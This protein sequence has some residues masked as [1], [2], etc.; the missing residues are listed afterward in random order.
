MV[1]DRGG[2]FRSGIF[3]LWDSHCRGALMIHLQCEHCGRKLKVSDTRA[4]KTGRCP[5]CKSAVVVPAVET[6]LNAGP[7]H[8][9]EGVTRPTDPVRDGA[10]LDLPE[11]SPI[12]LAAASARPTSEESAQTAHEADEGAAIERIEPGGGSRMSWPMGAVLFPLNL[13]GI[14]HLIGIW[15]LL[16]L[17]CPAVIAFI[18]LGIEFVPLVYA[19]PIAYAVYYVT[20]CV[21][22]GAGGHGGAPDF[23]MHSADSSK[24]ACVSQAFLVLGCIAVCFCPASVCYIVRE[25]TDW[26]FWLPLTC[27][28]FFFPMILLA[29]VWFDSFAGLN[30]VSMVKSIARTFVPYCAMVL[31]LFGEAFLFVTMGFRMSW[32][33]LPS[34]QIL[35]IRVLQLYLVLVAAGLLGGFYYR[36][37]DKLEWGT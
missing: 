36:Y 7:A 22:H 10:F 4:G 21:R 20:E 3:G 12:P 9:E 30:P 17:L 27:G 24:W 28:G 33:R 5:R 13:A 34:A 35:A 25:R 37:Q 6:S 14:I 23:W 31:L 26:G 18:G 32:M 15:L 2:E 29:V 8:P 16:F 1:A 11:A 19:L